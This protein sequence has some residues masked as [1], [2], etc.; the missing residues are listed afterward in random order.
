MLQAN[1]LQCIRETISADLSPRNR[2]VRDRA[3]GSDRKIA[4]TQG[5]LSGAAIAAR[6]QIACDE[7]T[8]RGEIIWSIIQRC[9]KSFGERGDS[10]L[11]DLQ[12]QINEFVGAEAV[13][14][15]LQVDGGA[16]AQYPTQLR[17]HI[18]D[19]LTVR[20]IELIT[21]LKNEARFYVQ[22]IKQPPKVGSSGITIHGDV[23]SLQTG[24]NAQTHIHIN[25]D[26]GAGLAV[27]LEKLSAAI[28]EATEMTADQRNE[29]VEV[30]ND[31]IVAARAPKP[32]GPKLL[33]LMSGLASTIRTVASLRPAWEFVRD[34]ARIMGIPI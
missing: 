4:S 28:M 20:R 33:G 22:D 19:A 7:L 29:S 24:D 1:V 8:V 17:T 11:A 31:L 12:H 18:D 16:S 32:N 6:A 3:Q 10:L 23:G 14:V 25:A 30:L 9:H 26:G 13:V 15:L 21:K 2:H 34:N 27:A 5:S